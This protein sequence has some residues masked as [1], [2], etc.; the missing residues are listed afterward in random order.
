MG[1]IFDD[2]DQL[3]VHLRGHFDHLKRDGLTGE[4]GIGSDGGG[5]L[6][7]AYCIRKE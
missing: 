2:G 7:G 5:N 1:R 3:A 4:G 6:H